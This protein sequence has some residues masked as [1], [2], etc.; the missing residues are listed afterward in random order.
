MKYLSGKVPAILS[1]R[2]LS[3]QF[4]TGCVTFIRHLTSLRLS[5]AHRQDDEEA[6]EESL[7]KPLST[8]K[9]CFCFY[10]IYSVSSV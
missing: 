7:F 5:S 10:N 1:I 6:K 3:A 8:L 2:E 4:L 9:F